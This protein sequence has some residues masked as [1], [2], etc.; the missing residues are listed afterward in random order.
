MAS[1]AENSMEPPKLKELLELDG[2]L[3]SFKPEISRRYTCFSKL[4]NSI[5]S[6][7]TGGLDAFTQGYKEFGMH[8]RPDGSVY[9]KEWCPNA[10]QLFLWGEFN[11]W[12]REQY[13]FTKLDHGKWELTIPANADGSCGIAHNSIVKLIVVDKEGKHLDRLSPWATY[14]TCEEKA[15]IYD[16]R[17]WNP[18]QRYSFKHQHP[19]KPDRLRI[20]EA[21]VGISSWE[22]KVATY[23]H[24]THDMLDRIQNLGYNAIQLMA[25]MEHAYYGS[26]GYQ[27][28]SFYAAS[29]RFGN[30]EELK[31]LIDAAHQRGLVVLLDIVHSHASKNTVDGLNQFDG[32]NGGF[33]HDNRRGF[34]DLWDSRLFNYTEWE[35]I[36]FLLSNLRWWIDEYRFDGFRFDG[37]T[38]ML[39]HSHGLGD[40][41]SGDYSEYFGL[42]TDT[43]SVVYFMLANHF[44]HKKYPFV[45]TVAEEVSGMPALCRPVEEGGQGF[46]Y[47]LAMA[48]PDKWIKL[49]K[50]SSDDDW[51]MGDIVWTLINRRHGEKHIAYA[52]SHD[53]AL[54]GDKTLA[55]WLMDKDMYTHMSKMSGPSIVIDRGMALHKMIRLI[56]HALGGE[57]YLNFIGN[58][59]GHPEWLDFPRVGNNE[60]YHYARRQFNLLDDDL[61]NYRLL[62]NFDRDMNTT[63]SKFNWLGSPQ[64]FV[65]RKNEGDKV[66]VFE[67]GGLVF[68]FNFHPSQSYSNYKIG[69]QAGG[70]YSILLDTD[71]SEYGGQGRLDHKTEFHTFPEG[72]D[73]RLNHMFVYIPSRVALI[74]TKIR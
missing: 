28:T 17:F 43:D 1:D 69:V 73:S 10:H 46:D 6:S 24:F 42:N 7:E 49:L 55:F 71:D 72:W 58:E 25:V 20:Y 50:E 9:C 11:N 23:K 19:Q 16:Q 36:R 44:L 27:V 65:S 54:V 34:H 3:E 61:L 74:F 51:N 22:G 57:G 29:S 63:E 2:Y 13:P 59:F 15:V 21:H 56:T 52:E 41:F 67:R 62:N 40:G 32:T 26:F 48:I 68:V 8:A 64:A 30:P 35:V 31:E 5:E 33:F 39:Y 45:I 47:R 4:L 70:I 38:S 12:T 18:P 53:Q 14:V 60:S 37:T 66:V